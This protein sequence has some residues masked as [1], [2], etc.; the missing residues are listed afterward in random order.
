MTVEKAK[1][2]DDFSSVLDL[3]SLNDTNYEAYYTNTTEG[4]GENPTEILI[5]QMKHNGGKNYKILFAGFKGCGKSTELLRLKR[6][7]DDHFIIHIFSVLDKMD[8]NNFSISE[9]MISITTDLLAYVYKNHDT[10]QLSNELKTKLANWS[11]KTV[12]EQISY[13]YA[14]RHIGAGVDISA[15]L[16][17]I[18]NFFAKLSFD[19][20]MGVNSRKPPP[21]KRNAH[22]QS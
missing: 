8:P 9:L 12:K 15:G 11:E 13:N 4:R 18:L 2:L 10:I 20:K 3:H 17:K 19:F 21:L 1:S 14:E 7:L 6:E 16:G 5:R 22:F